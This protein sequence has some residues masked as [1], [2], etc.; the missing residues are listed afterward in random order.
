[1][2]TPLTVKELKKII[3]DWPE[4]NRDGEPTEVWISTGIF[5][6]SQCTSFDRLNWRTKEDGTETGDILLTPVNFDE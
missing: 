4:E 6:S 2:K 3:A 1:M 5:L